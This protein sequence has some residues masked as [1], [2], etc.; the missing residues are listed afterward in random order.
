MKI[1]FLFLLTLTLAFSSEKKIILGSYVKE[2]NS[3][4]TLSQ[5]QK[6]IEEDAILKNLISINNLT[7]QVEKLGQYNVVSVTT[8]TNYTQLLRTM[9]ALRKYYADLYVLPPYGVVETPTIV[10]KIVETKEPTLIAK[11]TPTQEDIPK[12]VPKQVEPIVEQ[13]VAEVKKEE[14]IPQPSIKDDTQAS[15]HSIFEQEEEPLV[16]KTLFTTQVMITIAIA[17][18]L[19]LVLIGIIFKVSRSKKEETHGRDF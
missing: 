1:L 17:I 18:I 13:V 4:N 8:L 3:S 19:L 7:V 6:I 12:E 10:H 11:E 16:Q 5:V 14:V 2:M 9:K 15:I